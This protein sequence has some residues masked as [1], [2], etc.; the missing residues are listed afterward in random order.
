MHKPL[1]I[2]IAL[3]IGNAAIAADTCMVSP[4]AK[5]EVSGRFGKFRQGGAANFGSGNAKP[6]MHD[7][8][9]FSTSGQN[10][11]LL[12]T[13]AGTVTWAKLRGSAGNTVM[14]RRENGEVVAYY[15]MSYI[16]VKEGDKIE[17]GQEIG[18]AGNTGMQQSGAVHLHFIYGVPTPDDARVKTFSADAAKNPTFN[19]SQLP[20]AISKKSVEFNYPTDPSP[21]FCKTYHIQDDGL[22]PV[23]GSDTKAQYAKLFGAAPPLGVQPS[24]QFDAS[25]IASAN[26]DALQASAKGATTMVALAGVLNDADGY[27][28][29]PSAPIG[30]YE[31]MSPAE[32]LS[33]EARRRF[34]DIEW[35]TNVTKVSSRALWIDYLRAMGVSNYL[36]LAIRQKKERME[37]LLSMYTS[38]KL[39]SKREQVDAVRDHIQRDNVHN[40]IK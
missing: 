6:H 5:E 8:L 32:M 31:T 30:D 36:Q 28:A 20:N 26:G 37:M 35:N 7:G 38:Q 34:T 12:A 27:G 23:L 11:P 21:Y 16:G 24:T 15:H 33:T 14:I 10:A 25:N 17:A 29:L 19:P 39:A 1:V 9:D 40:A 22:Y 13:S 3:T 18:R 2:A 4:T